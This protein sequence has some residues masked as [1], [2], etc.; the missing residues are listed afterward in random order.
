M[1]IDVEEEGLFGGRYDAG[2]APVRNLPYLRT[3]DALFR[4]L[5]IRPTLLVTYQVARH[6]SVR[7]QIE[8]LCA[9]WNG[10]MG[11]HLHPW[12]TPP[13]HRG[14]GKEPICSEELPKDLLAAKL[15]TLLRTV[16]G[17]GGGPTSF[18]MGRFN[19]GP[20]MWSLLQATPVRVDSSIAPMRRSS[21]G[22]DHLTAAID[23]YFPR[24][25]DPCQPGDSSVLEVPITIVP[26]IPGLGDLLSGPLRVLPHPWIE[27]FA[28]K[29]ASLP[30][31]PTWTG[32]RR[33]KAAARLHAMR[34]GQV[35]T[36]F[37]HSSELMP[38]ASPVHPTESHVERF[39]A[40]TDGFLRWLRREFNSEP[41]TLSQLAELH[42]SRF[43]NQ[44]NLPPLRRGSVQ[45]HDPTPAHRF[46]GDL[47]PGEGPRCGPAASGLRGP[48]GSDRVPP[49]S[50][51]PF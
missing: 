20:R 50:A 17:G 9:R 23:P 10:E 49:R 27:W 4:D 15:G 41:V 47:D 25:S 29:L 22:P 45:G 31:Q 51:E 44:T 6:P 37:F 16:G 36:L 40:R 21:G 28:M 43:A 11:A 2:E 14:G 5:D 24:V 26:V 19:M 39:L 18:R 30:A 3:L 48:P 8:G 46:G 38:G 35:M 12:N 34:G 13:L 1:T 33:L 7:R 32:L 42:G